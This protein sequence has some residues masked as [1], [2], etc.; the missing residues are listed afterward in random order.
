MG[1]ALLHSATNK[2]NEIKGTPRKF[3]DHAELHGTINI[4]Q[5]RD[6]IQRELDSLKGGCICEDL[7]K[8]NKAKWKVLNLGWGNHKDKQVVGREWIKYSSAEDNLG[9]LMGERLDMTWL[10][11]LTAQAAPK[12][13]WPAGEGRGF[14]STSLTAPLL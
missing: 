12:S 11:A 5:G 10:C 2:D 4:L 9:L 14:C 1:P 7:M 13:A 6:A 8:F 3:P